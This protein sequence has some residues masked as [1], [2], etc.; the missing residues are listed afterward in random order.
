MSGFEEQNQ[1]QR[2]FGWATSNSSGTLHPF[3]FTRRA[4]GEND[5]TL[6]IVYCGILISTLSIILMEFLSTLSSPDMRLW[7]SCDGSQNDLESYCPKS[8]TTYT[9]F[10]NGGDKNYGGYSDILVVDQHFA[11][12]IPENLALEGVAPLL[13]AGITVFIPMKFFGLDKAGMHVGVVGLGGLGHLAVK[14]GKA[15]GMKMSERLKQLNNLKLIHLLL[16][17]TWSK[18]RPNGEN[19]IT[20]KIL[21]CG[22][23]HS[24]LHL[25]KNNFGISSYPTVPLHEIAGVV[26]HVGSKV[27]KFKLGDKAE[28]EIHTSTIFDDGGD[29][30]YGGFSDILVVD[31]HFAFSTPENLSAEGLDKPAMHVGVVGLG[32]LGHLAVKFAKA[33]GMKVTVISTSPGKK[34]EAIQHLEADSFI[35]SYDM[36]QMQAAMGTMDGIFDTVSPQHPLMPLL[37]LLKFNGKLIMLSGPGLEKQT[38]LSIMPLIFWGIKEIQEMLNF[39]AKQ[40]V[41]ADVEVISMDHVNKAMDRLAKGDVRYRFVV[42]I[43]NTIRPHL[44]QA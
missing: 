20:I 30:N 33:L 28:W 5:I 15:F 17:M 32:G 38:E 26:T 18:W 1:T 6:K 16:V 25:I 31:Q 19:D 7:E 43:A 34:N 29:K 2:A 9:I 35:V 3:Y 22:I 13:C 8:I 11:V 4:N 21:Y 37:N 10:D 36:K 12:H 44:R 39:A 41:A 24:D 14:F 23:C 27:Q 40:Y 42:D